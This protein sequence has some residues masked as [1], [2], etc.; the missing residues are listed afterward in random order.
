MKNTF[1]DD[2]AGFG[3]GGH[4]NTVTLSGLGGYGFEDYT[5]GTDITNDNSDDEEG[6]PSDP[7]FDASGETYT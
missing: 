7:S 3:I 4:H 2:L 5:I 6:N 1:S